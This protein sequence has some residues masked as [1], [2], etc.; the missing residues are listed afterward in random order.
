M[1]YRAV[2]LS[3][4]PMGSELFTAQSGQALTFGVCVSCFGE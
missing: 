2:I 1:M 4:A 3:T